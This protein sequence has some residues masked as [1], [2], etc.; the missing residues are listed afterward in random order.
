MRGNFVAVLGAALLVSACAHVDLSK[1]RYL[2]T[3]PKDDLI[4]E[5]EISAPNVQA[6]EVCDLGMTFLGTAA[7]RMSQ[8]S[9][10]SANLPFTG[11]VRDDFN[12]ITINF[13]TKT[14]KACQD[15]LKRADGKGK[16]KVSV[17]CKAR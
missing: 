15:F 1:G 8:C 9:D 3:G 12:D 16:L 13:A 11:V 14:M 5:I 6:S 17:P 7:R 2:Q 10:V 4:S